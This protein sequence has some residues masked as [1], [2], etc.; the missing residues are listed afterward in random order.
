MFDNMDF[1]GDD[2]GPQVHQPIH[3]RVHRKKIGIYNRDGNFSNVGTRSPAK[4]CRLRV[5]EISLGKI[6]LPLKN[7]LDSHLAQV[8][9]TD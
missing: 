5:P 9:L 2:E 6:W 7:E 1:L 3:G 8:G 4:K